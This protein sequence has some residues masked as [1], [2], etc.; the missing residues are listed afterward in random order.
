MTTQSIIAGIIAIV[1]CWIKVSLDK[2]A[3]TIKSTLISINSNTSNTQ[4]VNVYA[5][6]RVYP[7][8]TPRVTA[9]DDDDD[10]EPQQEAA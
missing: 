1:V 7:S 4:T 10:V 9:V 8:K 3:N 2:H 6:D 5:H